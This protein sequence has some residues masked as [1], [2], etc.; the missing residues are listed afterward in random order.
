MILRWNGTTW[1]VDSSGAFTGSLFA[2][3]TFAGSSTEWAMGIG[4]S[5]QG[6]VLSH[7]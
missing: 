4:S 1:S 2:A 5:N 7:G 6:L 3:A